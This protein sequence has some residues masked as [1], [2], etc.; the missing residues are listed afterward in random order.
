M[1]SSEGTTMKIKLVLIILFITL[2]N[3]NNA[4]FAAPG[5]KVPLEESFLGESLTLEDIEKIVTL[6]DIERIEREVPFSNFTEEVKKIEH[7]LE[8]SIFNLAHGK[9][10]GNSADDAA[11]GAAAQTTDETP[12]DGAAPEAEL[13]KI[14]KLA[15]EILANDAR[16][17]AGGR[18]WWPSWFGGGGW[19]Q[20]PSWLFDRGGAANAGN[21]PLQPARA[22]DGG[23]A[24]PACADDVLSDSWEII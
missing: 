15:G 13:R 17:E 10:V 6:E 16:P 12:K 5:D 11:G 23:G 22:V 4:T 3:T 14:A 2:F 9:S 18:W 20:L 24:G 8:E 1:H 21:I 19:W 7:K